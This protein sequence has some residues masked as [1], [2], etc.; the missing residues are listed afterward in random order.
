MAGAWRMADQGQGAPTGAAG[1]PPLNWT[2]RS[3]YALGGAASWIKTK[4]LGG[5][6]LLYYNQ[7]IGLSPAAVAGAMALITVFDA[8]CD[9]LVGWLS[10]RFRHRWGRRHP[11][12]YF[13][14]VPVALAFFLI[15]NPP[16]DWSQQA[17][18]AYLVVNLLAINLFD[19]F[20]DLPST[21]LVPELTS[22]YHERTTLLMFRM[23]CGTF[24]GLAAQIA[25][26][27]YF[28]RENP[29]GTGGVLDRAGYLPFSIV[30]GLVIF[31]LII[32]SA[33]GTHSRIPYLRQL[34][35]V[36]RSPLDSLKDLTKTFADRAFLLILSAGMM[37]SIS[38]GVYT[39][40]ELYLKIY[41]FGLSQ[42]Q[43][44][45]LITAGVVASICGAPLAPLLTRKI[46]KKPTFVLC[47]SLSGAFQVIPVVL[48]VAGWAPPSGSHA[49]FVILTGFFFLH[50]I[51]GMS[52][53]V[54]MTSML[55][56][57]VEEVELK[58]GQRSEGV[59]LA[60]D[61]V[62]RKMVQSIGVLFAG[63]V[64]TII[65]FPTGAERGTVDPDILRHM[66]LL[67]IPTQVILIGTAALV[68]C[69]FPIDEARHRRNVEALR[70]RMANP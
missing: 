20:F 9:P 28:M 41:L 14:A 3:L 22:D 8:F 30:F 56:D 62:F 1:P 35:L 18:F 60:A 15:W 66:G 67:Y 39:G 37:R 2:I 36:R 48:Y 42:L 55:T 17:I 12:M 5:F 52:S 13:S 16:E 59:L 47:S 44:S 46:G 34:P 40:L 24:G 68:M 29:D 63:L 43:L 31:V 57:V 45:G 61:S 64:L 21:A 25:A 7:V 49:L 11:F 27:Q 53:S 69:L 70:A 32:A 6:L 10:D 58:T 4:A 26:Y 38:L 19:T 33:A 23:V 65:V 50:T 51:C 54:T